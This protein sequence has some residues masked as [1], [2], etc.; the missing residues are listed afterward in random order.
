M[1]KRYSTRLKEAREPV[2]I[3]LFVTGPALFVAGIDLLV[4][5]KDSISI[6]IFISIVAIDCIGIAVW[7][8]WRTARQQNQASQFRE[9]VVSGADPRPGS[10][11]CLF[12]AF[13]EG[14]QDGRA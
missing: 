9:S 1:K 13:I 2:L 3:T 4:I 11:E 7:S 14:S 6:I 12:S 10:S 5:H 8:T